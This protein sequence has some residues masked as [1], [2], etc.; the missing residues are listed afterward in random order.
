MIRPFIS[1]NR[2]FLQ[3]RIVGEGVLAIIVLCLQI[4]ADRRIELLRIAHHFAPILGLEPGNSS[5]RRMPWSTRSS[6]RCSAFGSA[7]ALV[8]TEDEKCGGIVTVIHQERFW[9]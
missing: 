5:M 2:R 4:G 7:G 6:G 1:A 3:G 8:A 9:F